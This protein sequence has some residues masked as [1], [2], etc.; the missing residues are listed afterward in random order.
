MLQ[1]HHGRFINLNLNL[2]MHEEMYTQCYDTV[3]VARVPVPDRLE[4]VCGHFDLGE[5]GLCDGRREE[6]LQAGVK[7]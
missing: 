6:H 5:S 7:L 3:G 1:A 4:E 2:T